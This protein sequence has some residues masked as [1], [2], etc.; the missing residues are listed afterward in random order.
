[1]AFY[2]RRRFAVT[3]RAADYLTIHYDHP[4][5][6]DGVLLK[7]KVYLERKLKQKETNAAENTIW[8]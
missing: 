7:D 8:I 5:V 1:M 6:E 2:Q 4:M 3:H